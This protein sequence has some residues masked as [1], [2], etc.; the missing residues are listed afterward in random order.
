M[1]WP[2]NARGKYL[3]TSLQINMYIQTGPRVLNHLRPGATF[4]FSHRFRGGQVINHNL[5]ELRLLKC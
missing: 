2:L 5:L 4:V 1:L 3:Q